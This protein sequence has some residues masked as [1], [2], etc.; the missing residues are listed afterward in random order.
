MLGAVGE[1]QNTIGRNVGG[2]YGE[3]AQWWQDYQTQK[4]TVRH[5][6]F[7]SALTATE[8]AEFDKAAITPG[9]SDE[10]V[11]KNLQRQKMIA[12]RA[13]RKLAA[14]YAKSGYSSEAI[15][16]AVGVP[17]SELEGT[18]EPKRGPG[19]HSGWTFNS[20]RKQYRDKAGN[21]YDENGKPVAP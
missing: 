8:K 15:E 5:A 16:A 9:M 20:A 17:M 1:L 11:S 3:Q 6:L 21:L 2:G 12:Q 4:N 18:P 13:A 14:A 10:T 19:D 7:G